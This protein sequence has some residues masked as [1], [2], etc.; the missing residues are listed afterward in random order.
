MSSRLTV[1]MENVF[2]VFDRNQISGT[3]EFHGK[4]LGNE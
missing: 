4:E 3:A 1:L 2:C